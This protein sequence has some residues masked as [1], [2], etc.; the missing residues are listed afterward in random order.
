MVD[1]DFDIY[2]DSDEEYKTISLN[3]DNELMNLWVKTYYK[4]Y[5]DEEYKKLNEKWL[6]EL[7]SDLDSNDYDNYLDWKDDKP[8]IKDV[9][10]S[11]KECIE[12]VIC[13][14]E[15]IFL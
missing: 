10:L 11:N 12:N 3:L 7:L 2:F 4:R 8:L 1:E 13:I 15:T 14:F 5:W 6:I 9:T